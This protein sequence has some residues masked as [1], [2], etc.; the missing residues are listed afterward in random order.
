M[1]QAAGALEAAKDTTGSLSPSDANV[2]HDVSFTL[3]RDAAQI[4]PSDWIIIQ[5]PT[6]LPTS[7]ASGIIGAFGTPQST[8]QGTTVYI[9][10]IALL[11]GTQIEITGIIA[12]NP[13]VGVSTDE[14]F[15]VA[16]D[17]QATLIRN[18]ASVQPSFG[19]AYISVSATIDS[20]MSSINLS[21]FTSPAAFTTLSENG[22]VIGTTSADGIGSFSFP[23]SGLNPGDH[24][25]NIS[26]ADTQSRTT[27]LTTITAY[28]PPGTLTSDTGILLSP[29]LQLDKTTLNQGD[30]LTASGSAKPNSQISLFTESPL[31]S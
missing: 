19:G 12:S 31:K 4:T 26:S 3:P 14:T 15:I 22:T 28:L 10:N 11:P 16:S 9:T 18:Q 6:Y 29:S 1:V 30:T 7:P 5:M 20:Q 17:Q 13:A 25:F 8:I 23:L 2:Q 27:A 24:N 21:G